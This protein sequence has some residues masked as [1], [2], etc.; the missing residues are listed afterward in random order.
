MMPFR[1]KGTVMFMFARL[2]LNK[3]YF[4]IVR[5]Q[6]DTFFIPTVQPGNYNLGITEEDFSE[7]SECQVKISRYKFRYK[8]IDCV[9]KDDWKYVLVLSC[10]YM[11][12]T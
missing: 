7:I 10:R 1:K 6:T 9:I 2:E 4:S 12:I 8:F 11:Y 5:S 3:N